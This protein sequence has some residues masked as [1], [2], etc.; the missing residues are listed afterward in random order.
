[1]HHLFKLFTTKQKD[2][3]SFVIENTA[4]IL[5]IR[6]QLKSQI[7]MIINSLTLNVTP[8]YMK[9]IG[10]KFPNVKFNFNYL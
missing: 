2:W 6:W 8:E 9:N 1:M 3:L 4:L 5:D 7:K 10:F